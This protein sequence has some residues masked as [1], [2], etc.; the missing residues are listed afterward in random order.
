MESFG[1]ISQHEGELH[2]RFTASAVS[3]LGTRK[4]DS[5]SSLAYKIDSNSELTY[6]HASEMY[7]LSRLNCRSG[8]RTPMSIPDI[9]SGDME[10]KYRKKIG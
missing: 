8:H 1:H 7:R 5:N 9:W 2:L 10:V 4:I 3:C 6:K